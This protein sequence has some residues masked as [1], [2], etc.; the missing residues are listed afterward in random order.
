M[1]CSGVERD[2]S[3]TICDVTAR[4]GP[5]DSEN[6][7]KNN[8]ENKK[9]K[10]TDKGELWE[11][12]SI[13]D[14]FLYIFRF[15]SM[16]EI[17]SVCRTEKRIRKMVCENR[18]FWCSWY[19]ICFDRKFKELYPEILPE[20]KS[21]IP[22]ICDI[23][24]RLDVQMRVCSHDTYMVSLHLERRFFIQNSLVKDLKIE[25]SLLGLELLRKERHH[26][27]RN[28]YK[29]AN[30]LITV[31]SSSSDGKKMEKKRFR[32]DSFNFI[33]FAMFLHEAFSRVYTVSKKL[34]W[35]NE[36]ENENSEMFSDN[37]NRNN[38]ETLLAIHGKAEYGVCFFTDSASVDLYDYQKLLLI[39]YTKSKGMT[40]QTNVEILDKFDAY[41]KRLNE[42]NKKRESSKCKEALIR[43]KMYNGISMALQDRTGVGFNLKR[44]ELNFSMSMMDY[45]N[46]R[47]NIWG[48]DATMEQVFCEKV[49]EGVSNDRWKDLCGIYILC[50]VI[51]M[52]KRNNGN[53]IEKKSVFA[54]NSIEEYFINKLAEKLGTGEVEVVWRNPAP[55]S[56]KISKQSEI[57]ENVMVLIV[58][59]TV[60]HIAITTTSIKDIMS[61]ID[62]EWIKRREPIIVE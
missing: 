47:K 48:R 43:M 52:A 42:N 38:C 56:K 24:E 25:Q 10:K 50:L 15:L 44:P 53:K 27:L 4:V 40:R 31:N 60:R 9:K 14:L 26:M 30:S 8:N 20:G 46:C 36:T 37:L 23:L 3:R 12:Y 45:T 59:E 54:I 35:D 34:S 55:S 39:E 49:M 1:H 62:E 28:V 61:R 19:A 17:D 41:M 22:F 21:Y 5:T 11:I 18:D 16:R 13:D 7:Q 2:D 6:Q 32:M 58:N 57:K 51:I 33:P 29:H